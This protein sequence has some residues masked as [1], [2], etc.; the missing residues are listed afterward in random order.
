MHPD[1]NTTFVVSFFSYTIVLHLILPHNSFICHFF[2]TVFVHQYLITLHSEF[3]LAQ[4][5]D[6]LSLIVLQDS[7]AQL[8]LV[9]IP[10]F[11]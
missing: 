9:K 1:E 6:D 10:K 3:C 5:Y 2:M 4:H 7:K 11:S 8:G